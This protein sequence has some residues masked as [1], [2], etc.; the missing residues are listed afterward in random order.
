MIVTF[1]VDFCKS[2]KQHGI[3][4]SLIFLWVYVTCLMILA[5]INWFLSLLKLD[6]KIA[7]IESHFSVVS[8]DILIN[9]ASFL[10]IKSARNLAKC[11]KLF[12]NICQ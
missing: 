7:S 8:R 2:V 11:N 12:K 5:V 3:V 6:T 4:K 10:D 1:F 9:I